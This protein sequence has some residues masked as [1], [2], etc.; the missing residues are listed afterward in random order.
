[1]KTFLAI[2]LKSFFAS[3][4]CI[5]R[6]LNPLTV[7]LVVADPLRTEKTIC[8][9]VTPALKAYGI[10]GRPRL[11]E[12]IQQVNAI[13]R[14]RRKKAGCALRGR[15]TDALRLEQ[16][17]TLE[18]DFITAPP[19]MALYMEY[20][21]RIYRI[22]LRHVAAEDIH[23]YSI[24]EV[25]IDATHYLKSAGC[26]AEE[27]ARIL[28]QEVFFETGI[29]ATAG[30]GSNL[31]LCKVAMDIVAKKMPADAF[32]VRIAALDE[33]GY[34][35][36]LWNH[37]PLTDF[38]RVGHGYS[39]KLEQ[40]GLYT[41]G[42]IA[43]CSLTNEDLLYRLFGV[44]AEL[45]ID[46]AWGWE[47]CTMAEIKAYRPSSTSLS[48]GQVLQSPYPCSKARLI[49][50][51]MADHLVLEMV[52]KELVTDQVVL[53]VGYDTE[54]IT[55]GYSGPIV[56]D[57]YGRPMPKPAHGTVRFP[58]STS[59][60]R[61]ILQGVGALF[62]RII[63]PLLPVRR[64]TIAACRLLDR[65]TAA[66]QE[67]PEQLQLF[68]DP[69]E[70]DALRTKQEQELH[71]EHSM[72]KAMLHLKCRFGKNAVFKGMNL[73]E[74]STARERNRQIGGHKA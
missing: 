67:P 9:A 11:F 46:H 34:R 2:D 30:I 64:I 71:R 35:R 8:L 59:S 70:L 62:D 36:L 50:L 40:N 14:D 63:D 38:W 47:P 18:L 45:L 13:N 72:Q 44:N 20:S 42:D 48:N 41:M 19:R 12:V 4:E 57:H 16:D 23:V 60:T 39:A 55:E 31:Y 65:H 29:T 56:I 28:L 49:T 66:E 6:G 17:E 33:L 21:T 10:P 1:M 74:G 27:F 43:R 61:E 5:E 53:T 37:R 69:M 58:R 68:Q 15:C 51:E 52:E 22:Y 54:G 7:N 26:T 25:F 3:V 32:G 24:D 73:R